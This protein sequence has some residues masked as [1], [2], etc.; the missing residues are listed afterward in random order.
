MIQTNKRKLQLCG[1]LMENGN[2]IY[3]SEEKLQYFLLFY[4]AFTQ[5]NGETPDWESLNENDSKDEC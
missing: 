2:E 5:L 4:E 1:W 3:E